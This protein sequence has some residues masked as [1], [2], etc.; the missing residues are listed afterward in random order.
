M[1]RSRKPRLP[2]AP[3]GPDRDRPACP[4]AS[5]FAVPK[6]SRGKGREGA[7]K[8]RGRRLCYLCGRMHPACGMP[9]E[10]AV[11]TCRTIANDSILGGGGSQC[12]SAAAIVATMPA[13]EPHAW[14]GAARPLL[15]AIVRAMRR[16]A[17]PQAH[18]QGMDSGAINGPLLPPPPSYSL[19]PTRRHPCATGDGQTEGGEG[20]KVGRRPPACRINAVI[21]T[22]S[23]REPCSTG[24]S[25]APRGRS[26]ATTR[27]GGTRARGW[28]S[29][30][31]RLQDT[32]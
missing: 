16:P 5:G 12:S 3:G 15:G 2:P 30:S 23:Y 22:A 13:A 21:T 7:R 26:C 25:S 9:P 18:M 14:N 6:P 29:Q 11:R 32:V 8:D 20:G 31:T 1:R 24:C 10:E 19:P 27:P 17:L 4:A 28:S